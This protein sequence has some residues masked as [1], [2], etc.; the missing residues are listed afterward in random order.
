MGKGH[1][2]ALEGAQPVAPGER[3]R[4]SDISAKLQL[5]MPGSFAGGL[6]DSLTPT[7]A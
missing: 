7:R 3:L 5:T 2:P 4:E 1:G 6:A